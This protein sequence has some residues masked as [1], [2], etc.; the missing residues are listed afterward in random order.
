MRGSIKIHYLQLGKCLQN[1]T[2][3]EERE[4]I[5]EFVPQTYKVILGAASKILDPVMV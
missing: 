3:E 1:I 5:F 4:G 2:N